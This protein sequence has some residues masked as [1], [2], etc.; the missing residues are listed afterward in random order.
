MNSCIHVPQGPDPLLRIVTLRSFITFRINKQL[1]IVNIVPT[2][3]IYIMGLRFKNQKYGQCF[4]VTT[5]FHEWTEY[6][7]IPSVYE[8]LADSC[9][10]YS[11]KYGARIIGYV[12]MPTHLH[13]L[14]LIDGKQLPNFMRDLKK[15]VA[16]K[17]MKDLGIKDDK[18]WMA[19]YDRQAVS[20]EM[21][22]RTKLDY[23]H[24]N[25]VRSGYVKGPEKWQWSSAG[26]YLT[27]T[28]GMIDIWKDWLF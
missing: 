1:V 22:F 3:N 8:A 28:S 13:M 18:I 25:P 5:T 7:D 9:R 27:G 12:F 16:Q 2:S 6:G 17:V 14:I 24:N 4:F 26:D 20:T 21:V 15:Y 10:Y 23:I 19:G 11:H